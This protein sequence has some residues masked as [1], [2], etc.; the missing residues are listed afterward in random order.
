MGYSSEEVRRLLESKQIKLLKQEWEEGEEG[1]FH[2]MCPS[3][4]TVNRIPMDTFQSYSIR[5][6][7]KPH[8]RVEKTGYKVKEPTGAIYYIILLI[9]N[10][11]FSGSVIVMGLQGEIPFQEALA[12]AAL[13]FFG[14]GL[15]MI[16]CAKF[17]RRTVY[18]IECESCTNLIY[19][20]YEPYTTDSS[21]QI[22]LLTVDSVGYD[23]DY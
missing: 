5:G 9:F 3:C 21:A 12:F 14:I 16:C 13:I 20:G 15:L 17:P 7:P 10:G 8:P 18:Q 4:E 23:D 2:I 11:L 1:H 22:G 19:V 6:K